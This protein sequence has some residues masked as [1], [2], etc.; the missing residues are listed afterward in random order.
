MQKKTPEKKPIK[1]KQR[2]ISPFEKYRG[3]GNG[4]AGFGRKAVVR[5][6]RELRGS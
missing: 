1:A 4:G 6:M 2:S 5:A 3:I